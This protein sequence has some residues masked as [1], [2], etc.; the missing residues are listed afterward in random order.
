MSPEESVYEEDSAS[1]KEQEKTEHL[2]KLVIRRYQWRSEELSS[3]FQSLE[4]KANRARSERGKRMLTKREV[5]SFL[6][7]SLHTFPKGAPALALREELR[8]EWQIFTM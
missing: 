2:A 6:P 7:G 5:G 1:E 4:R 8:H 3:E